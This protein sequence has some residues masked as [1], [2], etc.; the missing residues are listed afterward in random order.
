MIRLQHHWVQRLPRQWVLNLSTLG[1]LGYFKKAPGTV[2]SAAGLVLYILFWHPLPGFT[3]LL[4]SLL[5]LYIAV[6]VCD[7]SARLMGKVDPKEIILDECAAMPLC[8]WG[9][10]SAMHDGYLGLILVAGFIIFRGFD[11][12]KPLGI[13]D[14]ESRFLGGL[15]IVADDVVAALYTAFVLN[16]LSWVF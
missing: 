12:F 11:I 2:G 5:F 6:A 16:V 15:G 9:M 4:L 8:F 1:P 14:L 13:R 3:S 7:Q 10:G